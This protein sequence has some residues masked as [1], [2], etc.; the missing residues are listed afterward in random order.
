MQ[1]YIDA[2]GIEVKA[3]LSDGNV[4]FRLPDGD[5]APP[6]GQWIVM[7]PDNR[8]VLFTD[9]AFQGSFTLKN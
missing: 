5:F 2:D 4:I 3:Q 9:E 7:L 1:T 8:L 6:I